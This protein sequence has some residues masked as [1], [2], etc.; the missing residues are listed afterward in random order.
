MSADIHKYGYV[1]KGASVVLHRRDDWY[2]LQG[3]LYDKWGAGLYGSAAM[4]GARPASPIACSWAVIN[5]LGMEG[6]TEIVGGLAEL[7]TRFRSVADGLDGIEL[8][9]APIG[10]VLAFRATRGGVDLHAVADGMAERGWYLNRNI[11]PRGIQ[12]MLSPGHAQ[13]M[14]KLIADLTESV[15]TVRGRPPGTTVSADPPRYS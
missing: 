8:V 6:Y 9:G 4:A 5:Y 2:E 13:V 12:V 7:T 3:F 15:A 14:D 1:P 10:P 11:Q